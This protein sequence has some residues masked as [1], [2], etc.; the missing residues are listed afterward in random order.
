MARYFL[1]ENLGRRVGSVLKE[2]GF[3]VVT[4]HDLGLAGRPDVEW[5]SQVAAQDRIIITADANIRLVPAEKAAV[6]AARARLITVRIGK[7][8]TVINVAVNIVNSQAVLER[9]IARTDA[10]WIISLSMPDEQ[11]FK[12]GRPGKLSRNKLG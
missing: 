5:I 9:F 6:I 2:A 10:P 7:V 12:L 1:D 8:A 11:S 4:S 3:N